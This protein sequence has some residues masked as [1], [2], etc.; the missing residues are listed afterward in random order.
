M[1]RGFDSYD[2]QTVIPDASGTGSIYKKSTTF[3]GAVPDSVIA[4]FRDGVKGLMEKYL[5]EYVLEG[6]RYIPQAEDKTD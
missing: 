2:V 6:V 3:W 4:M 5:K 1:Y